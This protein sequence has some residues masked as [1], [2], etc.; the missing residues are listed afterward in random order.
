MPP[1]SVL[2]VIDVQVGFEDPSWGR[3]GR[4]NNPQAEDVCAALLKEWRARGWP[5]IHIQHDSCDPRSPLY[6]GQRGHDLK[7]QVAPRPYEMVL[8]K[9]VNSAFIGTDLEA[10]L[11]A[12]DTPGV[13]LCGLTTDHCVSTTTRMAANLGFPSWVVADACATFGRTG[14]DGT[15]FPAPVIHDTALASLHREFAHVTTS[16]AL[17]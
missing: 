1:G 13:V 17:S 14:A 6:P 15:T 12:L 9:Q 11:H 3:W 5:V 2:L 4:R 7:P 8:H 10:S 16:G